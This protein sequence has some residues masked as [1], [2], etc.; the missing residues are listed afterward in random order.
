[1]RALVTGGA[2]FIGKHLGAALLAAGHEVV[3]LD[4]L[5][6]ATRM[7]IPAGARFIEGDVR[8]PDTVADAVAGQDVVF[9]LAAQSNVMGAMSDVEYSFS[10]NVV[11]TFNVLRAAATAGVGRVVFASSREV[12]GEPAGIPVGEDAPLLARNPYGASKLA[13][14]AYCRAW[15]VFSNL[16]ASVLRF[17]NV[18][19]PGDSGRVIPL[20]LSLA[21]RG[22]PLPLYGG[23]QVLDFVPV[24]TAVRALIRASEAPLSGPINVGT[25][26]GTS[27]LE[28]AARVRALTG[29]RSEVQ[30]EPSRD[31]EV[32]QFIADVSRMRSHLGVEPPGDPLT[33]LEAL[34]IEELAAV[35]THA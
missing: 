12:Y 27:L 17:A 34:A 2:G 30:V 6:R 16:E 1:M 3:V 9:H 25:G 28:L 20:W 31:A 8:S 24:G 19:G 26:R 15:G 10:S 18:Y 29:F 22:E 11:G 4:N 32:V 13:G 35:P 7:A 23:S 5:H 33:G 14:E 21:A